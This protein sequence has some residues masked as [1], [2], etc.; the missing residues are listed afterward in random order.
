MAGTLAFKSKSIILLI[1]IGMAI[2]FSIVIY[3]F[4]AGSTAG[5]A[6]YT[7]PIPSGNTPAP[8][9]ADPL[10]SG[11]VHVEVIPV[12]LAE[13]SKGWILEL[14]PG[15]PWITTNGVAFRP[16]HDIAM[17]RPSITG[18]SLMY[19]IYWA[20]HDWGGEILG[21]HTERS[22]GVISDEDIIYATGIVSS[23]VGNMQSDFGSQP[24][25]LAFVNIIFSGKNIKSL[26]L[27]PKSGD[28]TFRF[29]LEY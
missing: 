15:Q 21:V 11:V 28:S 2:L 7:F 6:R 25:D 16:V 27:D 22:V 26:F 10:S 3:N 20:S 1:S 29:T 19:T 8:D 17:A 18:P 4:E 14:Y 23:F 24:A 13:G 9:L 12:L 5:A